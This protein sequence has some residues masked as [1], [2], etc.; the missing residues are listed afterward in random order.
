MVLP[1]PCLYGDAWHVKHFFHLVKLLELFALEVVELQ[2]IKGPR[3]KPA[4]QYCPR[5]GRRKPQYLKRP[6]NLLRR[7]VTW[8]EGAQCW[9]T[10]EVDERWR[11]R[12][13]VVEN[14]APSRDRA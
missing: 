2:V 8:E 12:P 9:S 7:C 10:G 4:G 1:F 6:H 14:G 3:S 5:V 11:M 13:V